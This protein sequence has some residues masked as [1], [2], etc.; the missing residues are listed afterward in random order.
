MFV[1]P[2]RYRSSWREMERL[3][4]ELNSL[5]AGLEPLEGA[6]TPGYPAINVWTSD[7]GAVVTAE[8]PGVDADGIDISVVGDTLALS[9]NRSP[10]EVDE[11]GA[12]HRRE[13]R[14][15]RFTRAVKLPFP[16][17]PDGVEA[18]F[19]KGVLSVSLPRLEADKPRKITVRAA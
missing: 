11:G 18:I 17:Q 9:G 5:V 7:N 2:Y 14:H 4:R 13:R 12:Y 3:R 8:L 15:G 10:D 16:A 19:D 6:A 1:R